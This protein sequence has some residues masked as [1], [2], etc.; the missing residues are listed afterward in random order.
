MR[1]KGRWGANGKLT[2]KKIFLYGKQLNSHLYGSLSAQNHHNQTDEE[3][4]HRYRST[5]N[6]AWLGHLLQRYTMLLLGVAMKYLKDKDAAQDAVQHI[7]LKSLT[8]LPAGEIG[9][10]KGWLY[11]LMRNHC[12]QQ[13]RDRVRLAGEE[14]IQYIPAETDGREEALLHEVT[15]MAMHAALQ[16]LAAEQQDC[17][18]AFYLQRKSYQQIMGE[19]GFSFAQVKS[20]IQNGKRNL[21]II[22]SRNTPK[23]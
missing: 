6:N 20:Y 5:G 18:R 13:L 15:L 10:F 16:E 4:L 12:L 11:I 3:L 2:N 14:T 23:P 21:K 9:N 7:F 8:H 17:I 1:R 22:L 19:T